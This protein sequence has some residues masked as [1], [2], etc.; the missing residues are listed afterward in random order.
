[1][2]YVYVISVNEHVLLGRDDDPS[3]YPLASCISIVFYQ[4]N[5][6]TCIRDNGINDTLWLWTGTIF[7]EEQVGCC[8]P[9][10]SYMHCLYPFPWLL[11]FMAI[12]DIHAGEK[13]G[14]RATPGS[15]RE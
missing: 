8:N 13:V 14:M 15:R 7:E 9:A 10:V 11:F 4:L 5:R 1:M 3:Q 6:V 12:K 2:C